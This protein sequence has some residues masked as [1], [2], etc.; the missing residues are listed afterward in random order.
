MSG[1]T[2]NTGTFM[3]S[4]EVELLMA[5]RAKLLRVAGAAAQLVA[6]MDTRILPERVTTEADI[7]A[8]SVNA[9]PED[10]LKDALISISTRPT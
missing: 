6:A 3:L 2:E 8:E 9:L 5:E 4:Q 7:L 1:I 10:T